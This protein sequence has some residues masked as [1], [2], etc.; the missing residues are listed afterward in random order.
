MLAGRVGTP[1]DAALVG[2]A[3]LALEEEL[4]ALAPALLALG[5]GVASHLDAPPLLRPAAVV[6]L[7]R[8]VLDRGHVEAGGLQRADRRLAAGAGALGEDL[9]PLQAVLHALLG[10]GVG[11]H[12]GG[13]RRRLAGAFEAG[14]A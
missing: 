1:L 12:L 3:A 8:D 13:E 10:G 9:D 5:G 11:G 7:R 6:G 14:R 4:L 2:E